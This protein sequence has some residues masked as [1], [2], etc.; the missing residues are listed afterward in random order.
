[1]TD[2]KIDWQRIR[3]E[4]PVTDSYTYLNTASSGAI[5]KQTATAI[6]DFYTD[7]LHHAAIH[8]NE[9]LQ[10]ISSARKRAADLLNS[11]AD[12]IGFVGDVSSAMNY[13]ADKISPKKQIILIRGD[14]PSVNIPW[15]MRGFTIRWV[16]QEPDHSI[17]ID[18]IEKAIDEGGGVVAISWVQYSSGFTIDLKALSDICR[19]SG[20]LLVVDGTQGVGAIPIDLQ[21]DRVDVLIAS[22]FKWQGA[23]YGI[24]LYYERPDAD[25][26][27]PVKL[28]GW[29]SLHR[30]SGEMNRDNLRTNASAIEAG[31]AKYA[32]LVALNSGLQ[33]MQQIGWENIY[34]RNEHL[35]E[36][37]IHR[38][39]KAGVVFHS[40]VE[41]NHISTILCIKAQDELYDYFEKNLVKVT[42]REDY[43]RLSVHYY[44]S[45]SDIDR[46]IELIVN[47]Q[48]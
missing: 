37:L 7:Q 13:V 1:M 6:T 28:T 36:Y 8:R 30:F 29:N 25:F 14:F 34:Q 17:S 18:K 22:S 39:R 20:T 47:Y 27:S 44:N 26:D 32:S 2:T 23:G 10:V 24:C 9:W 33:L 3:E 35:R 42:K 40:P 4:F 41:K 5:A 16:D 46:A 21:S 38:L 19:K 31:H 12:Q 48:D 15:V 11:S 43:I 45:E